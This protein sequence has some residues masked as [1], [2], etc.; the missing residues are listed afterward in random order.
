LEQSEFEERD[1]EAEEKEWDLERRTNIYNIVV[2]SRMFT[3]GRSYS[4]SS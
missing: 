3:F 4:H 2:G 1:S